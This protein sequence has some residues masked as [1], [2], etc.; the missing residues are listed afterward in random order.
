MGVIPYI[1]VVRG[2]ERAV[3][4]LSLSDSFVTK[5]LRV[6]LRAEF[7]EFTFLLH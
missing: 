2:I 4:E 6:P 5:N 1:L 3:T 7:A